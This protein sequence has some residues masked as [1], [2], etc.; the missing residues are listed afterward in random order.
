MEMV[1]AIITKGLSMICNSVIELCRRYHPDL[2]T[3]QL[4]AAKTNFAC[5]W[6][7]VQ[8]RFW[9]GVQATA[10]SRYK[11]WYK[12][13]FLRAENVCTDS[14]EYQPSTPCSRGTKHARTTDSDDSDS[15]DAA[16]E[17]GDDAVPISTPSTTRRQKLQRL[18]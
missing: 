14:Q 12:E 4:E 13:A 16:A 7:T 3:T 11:R 6:I 15:S 18:L 9:S 5:N 17:D 8:R 2:N 1:D 10:Y